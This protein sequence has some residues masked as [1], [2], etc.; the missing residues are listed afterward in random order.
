MNSFP[1]AASKRGAGVR[2][3]CYR[4]LVDSRLQSSFVKVYS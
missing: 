4:E 3:N 2:C 1:G